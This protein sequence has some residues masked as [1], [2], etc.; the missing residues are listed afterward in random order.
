[1]NTY[2]L[3]KLIA[4][5]DEVD[6]RKRLQKC[7]YLLQQMGCDLGAEYYLHL[8]GPYSRDVA[9]ATDAL[10]A[11]GLVQENSRD[12]AEW[13]TQYSYS[14]TEEGKRHLAEYENTREGQAS[15]KKLEAYVGEFSKMVNEDLW[16]LELAST[17]V[18]FLLDKKLDWKKAKSEAI[19][20]KNA[21]NGRT[22]SLDKAE[23]LAR[24]VVE[25]VAA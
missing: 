25:R 11:S 5:V 22:S 7:L 3:A 24:A 20:F 18:F 15:L 19:K 6:S 1:V 2:A 10:A 8:Y 13:G 14:I 4:S 16:V 9:D 23:T 21:G 17:M 12:H